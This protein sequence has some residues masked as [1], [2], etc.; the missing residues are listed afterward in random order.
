M[1]VESSQ[2]VAGDRGAQ[3]HGQDQLGD[4]AVR[5]GEARFNFVAKLGSPKFQ[6][7]YH[8]DRTNLAIAE[9]TVRRL[10]ARLWPGLS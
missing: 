6:G 3:P 5:E 9:Y 4:C 7:R 8:G 10:E 2:G 1:E